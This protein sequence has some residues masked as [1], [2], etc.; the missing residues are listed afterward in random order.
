MGLASRKH[1]EENFD[2][3]EIV[4]KTINRLKLN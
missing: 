1:M 3:K 4:K 2:K